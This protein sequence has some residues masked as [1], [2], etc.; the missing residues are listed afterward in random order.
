M[1]SMVV[2]IVVVVIV[3]A[4]VVVEDQ[5]DCDR[6]EPWDG[7]DEEALSGR[8]GGSGD[9]LAR[10]YWECWLCRRCAFMQGS[11]TEDCLFYMTDT[12][13]TTFMV[14]AINLYGVK[15]SLYASLTGD[16]LFRPS[17][18]QIGPSI[19]AKIPYG[20]EFSGMS[21]PE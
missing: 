5:R 18:H 17:A 13:I 12:I 4:E 3:V 19:F 8:P 6:R 16:C 7:G 9:G 2:V 20:V 21:T 1:E 11:S 15:N 14:I 10:P